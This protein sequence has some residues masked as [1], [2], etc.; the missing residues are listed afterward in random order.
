MH[1][2][3]PTKIRNVFVSTRSVKN[4][5]EV[6]ICDEHG[7]V[8]ETYYHVQNSSQRFKEYSHFIYVFNADGSLWGDANLFFLYKVKGNPK[9]S[10]SRMRFF[11]S[12]LTEFRLFCD[13]SDTLYKDPGTWDYEDTPTHRFHNYLINTRRSPK[14]GKR[15]MS[16]ITQ[17]YEWLFSEDGLITP[18]PLWTEKQAK[19]KSGYIVTVKDVCQFPGEKTNEETTETY[20]TDGEHLRPLSELEQDAVLQAVSE[21]DNPEYKLVFFIALESKAR[22]QT[23]LTLRL[24]H[25]VKS[26]PL[27]A[28]TEDVQSWFKTIAWPE[29]TE[30]IKIMVGVGHDADSKKG[31]FESYPIYI[32]GW[33]WKRIIFYIASERAFARRK[34]ALPQKEELKQYLFLTQRGNAMYH[35][36]NDLY[37]NDF[38]KLG[39]KSLKEGGALDKWIDETL[40][41]K[42]EEN[43]HHFHFKFH[44][45]RATSAANFLE[46]KRKINGSY[47]DR[48]AWSDDIDELAVR[49]NHSSTKT[50]WGYLKHK[51]LEEEKPM[52]QAN[53]EKEMMRLISYFDGEAMDM[54]V[55]ERSVNGKTF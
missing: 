52:A 46:T 41:P 7:E 42:L 49:M 29:D 6:N 14:T 27:S 26:L 54:H 37:Y 24:H 32:H 1:R 28:S 31:L 13:E 16:V 33:L 40:K 50:T 35:A 23:I 2:L 48:D 30:E 36:K 19:T 39:L 9:L 38:N 44:D 4:A 8:V 22:K 11:A 5:E 51:S 15:V 25:F 43:G 53:Y 47:R 17:F 55:V 18:F 20:V 34:K 10:A 3:P 21:I 45:L 12:A